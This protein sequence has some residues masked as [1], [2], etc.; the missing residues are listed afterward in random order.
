MKGINKM[1]VTP[2]LQLKKQALKIAKNLKINAILDN[3]ISSRA[4]YNH[5]NKFKYRDDATAYDILHE[6][7]HIISGYGCCREHD[8]YISHGI[9][10]GI[11][12]ISNMELGEN[13]HKIIESY[14]GRSSH[15]GCGAIDNELPKVDINESGAQIYFSLDFVVT[16]PNSVM[17]DMDGK[18]AS[19]EIICADDL[20]EAGEQ[21]KEFLTFALSCIIK[22]KKVLDPKEYH[23]R[24]KKN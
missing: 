1:E 3:S 5:G 17:A 12:K 14:A 16:H 10:L 19:Y 22:G 9:A 15:I 20:A 13:I 2:E 21:L 6:I 8:E 4:T 11:A 18:D 24:D 7:G 23:A